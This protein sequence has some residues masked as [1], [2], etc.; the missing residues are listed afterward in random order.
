MKSL[1]DSS[2]VRPEERQLPVPCRLTYVF[3]SC[4]LLELEKCA[5]I[6]DYWH[7]TADGLVRRFCAS[8]RKRI[9]FLAS[10]FHQDH[11][12]RDIFSMPAPYAEK[13]FL[14]SHDILRRHRADRGEAD[15]F[16]RRIAPPYEDEYLRVTAC[17][18]TDV[19]ISLAVEVEGMAVFHAGDLNNWHWEGESS[20]AEVRN[21]EG[22]FK[23]ALRTIRQS[24]SHFDLVMFPVDPRIGGE[25]W[26]GA[27]QWLAAID[28]SYFVPMHFQ[29]DYAAPLS[30]AP[31]AEAGGAVYLPV[32][33]E[34]ERLI[35]MIK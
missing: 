12:S 22:N 28:T 35:D 21:M 9:Y 19:G 2:P 30:F 5:L 15:A 11:F 25:F 20:E 24:F 34:G 1:C 31:F 14:L 13:R 27:R 29:P 8:T 26:R 32:R 33:E 23:A 3:H 4:F 7:D 10:H 6:F 18:S 16:L 17:P